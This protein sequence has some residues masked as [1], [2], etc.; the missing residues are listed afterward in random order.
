[1]VGETVPTQILTY[2]HRLLP[3]RGQHRR[4]QAALDHSRDLYNAALQ[5]R[6]DCY[7]K[8]GKA[9]GHY[10]QT[11][12]LTDLRVDPAWTTYAV[13]MQRWPLVQLDRAFKAFFQRVKSGAKPG[14]PRFKGRGRFRTFGF[15]EA[16]GWRVE[17]GRV[18]MKGI[19]SIR[20][21]LHRPIPRAPIACKVMRDGRGWYA[22]LAV[23][24]P[25]AAQH[26]GAAVGV[27]LGLTSLAALSTGEIIPN[28]R[29]FV[30]AEK[31][32]RKHQRAMSRC[33]RGSKSRGKARARVA[34]T[35][36]KIRN[37]RDTR[38]HQV[39]A[40]LVRRFGLIAVEKLNI[41]GLARTAAAKSINDTGWAKLIF[42]L[43]YKAAKAGG[44]VH[45]V[46]SRYT[47]QTCPDCGSIAP[48]TLSDRMHECSCGSVMD[49][50]VAAAKIIL[51][52]AVTGPGA[53]NVGHWPMRAL[54]N[55]A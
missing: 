43:D 41:K 21:H 38:L 10:D 49:R 50:D 16:K 9:R 18:I 2:K 24:V 42:L 4:L 28:Q 34:A 17:N 33:Q 11:R 45:R 44:R 26:D 31:A 1:M 30:R 52:R 36:K 53:P 3:S 51:H 13:A 40:D 19:G 55:L 48:K 7:R 35:H 39:S 6:I 22:L 14:F 32:L 8:T 15:S 54:G 27:D 5:E 46:D 47:S 37:A 23:E 12:S 29:A 20:L 25:N